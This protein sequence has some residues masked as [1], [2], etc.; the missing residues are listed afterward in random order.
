M[1]TARG[2]V[3]DRVHG[4]DGGADDYLTKPFHL[5]ELFARIRALI[6]RGPV[7]AADGADCRGPADRHCRAPLLA[8]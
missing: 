8:R 5:D 3:A 2:A 7:G 1:L 6:R 4:L